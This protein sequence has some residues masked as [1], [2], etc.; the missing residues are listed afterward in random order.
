[1]Q[2][3]SQLIIG[4]GALLGLVGLFFAWNFYTG[5]NNVEMIVTEK[6]VDDKE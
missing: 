5:K 1:M 2:M 6:D 4:G 3:K